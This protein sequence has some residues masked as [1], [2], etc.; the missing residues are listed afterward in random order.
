MRIYTRI[1]IITLALMLLIGCNEVSVSEQENSPELS[2]DVEEN[3]KILDADTS[4]S[5][6]ISQTEPNTTE[7]KAETSNSIITSTDK[8]TNVIYKFMDAINNKEWD[9]FVQSYSPVIQK[10]YEGFPSTYQIENRTGILSVDSIDIYEAK[11]L[12]ETHTLEIEP[13]FNEIDFSLYDHVQ[14]YYIGFDFKVN[15]E[16]EFFYNGVKYELVA[17]G[18]IDDVEYIVGHENVYYFSKLEKYNYLFNSSAEKKA[19]NVVDQRR[20]GLIVNFNNEIIEDYNNENI[21]NDQTDGEDDT[22]Q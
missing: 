9:S 19:Q 7:E 22:I 14:F 10:Y 2:L 3:L 12:A 21:E 16:S 6:P 8:L 20:K 4:Q 15:K 11:R 13:Y 1:I 17:V 5:T 18:R